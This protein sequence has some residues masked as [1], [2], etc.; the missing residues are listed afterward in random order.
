MAGQERQLFSTKMEADDF[1]EEMRGFNMPEG[2][3]VE[4]PASQEP[5]PAEKLAEVVALHT[6]VGTPYA[7][8]FDYREVAL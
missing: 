6:R 7:N 1:W 4:A 5:T 8:G 3:F 2:G